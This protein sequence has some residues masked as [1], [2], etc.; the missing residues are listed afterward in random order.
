MLLM[1][2][3][4]SVGVVGFGSKTLV[5]RLRFR[6]LRNDELSYK[7]S[8]IVRYYEVGINKTATVKTIDNLL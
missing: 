5:D 3:L 2:G 4:M 8:F 1:V 7:E 6:S